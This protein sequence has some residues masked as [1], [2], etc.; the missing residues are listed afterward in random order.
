MKSNFNKLIVMVWCFC[1]AGF[2]FADTSKTIDL[3]NLSSDKLSAVY[4]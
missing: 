4:D 2:I 1:L 3:T